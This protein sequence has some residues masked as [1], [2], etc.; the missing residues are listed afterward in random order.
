MCYGRDVTVSWGGVLL[1]GVQE[2]GVKFNGEAVDISSDEDGGYQV[3]CTEDAMKSVEVSLSGVVKDSLLINDKNAGTVQK[4]VVITWANG[5]TLTGSFN[6]MGY[7]QGM[8]K[9]DAVTFEGTLQSS[10]PW[11]YVPAV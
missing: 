8:A 6:L 7:S 4:A 5:A 10:G 11:V 2:K 9:D 1:K 3:L